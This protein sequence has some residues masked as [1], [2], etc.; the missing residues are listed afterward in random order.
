MRTNL[1]PTITGLPVS[2][3]NV[4]LKQRCY[5]T[6]P[7]PRTSWPAF[8]GNLTGLPPIRILAGDDEAVLIT[9]AV[10]LS[11]PSALVLRAK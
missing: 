2:L 4:P 9:L 10:T 1:K 6:T 5:W 3:R 11:A 7:T 8:Y